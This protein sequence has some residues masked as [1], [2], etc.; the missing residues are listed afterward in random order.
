MK[1]LDYPI[2]TKLEHIMLKI[3]L[4][5]STLGAILELQSHHNLNIPTSNHSYIK[6]ENS[7]SNGS[8]DI[9]KL[10]QRKTMFMN[11][12]MIAS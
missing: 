10:R 1:Q 7:K 3:L 11:T 8:E 5:S 4:S 12:Y 2:C 9:G 6:L